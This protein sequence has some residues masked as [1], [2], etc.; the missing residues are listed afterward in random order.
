MS[1]ILLVKGVI[2]HGR[3]ADF[4]AAVPA[5]VEYRR[6]RGWAV[7]EVLHG[8]AGPMNTVL[9]IFR[10]AKLADWEVECAAERSDREYGRIASALPYVAGTITYE[11]YQTE[12][13]LDSHG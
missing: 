13:R 10:Y 6:Q 11:L 1:A 7:P 12:D 8:L 9:M 5:F 2:A 3:L 4:A